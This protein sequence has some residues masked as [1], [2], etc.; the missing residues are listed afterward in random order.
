M[1]IGVLTHL[2]AENQWFSA[3]FLRSGVISS[4]SIL[5][6]FQHIGIA[7]LIMSLRS[8]KHFIPVAVFDEAVDFIDLVFIPVAIPP[9]RL[10]LIPG[11]MLFLRIDP[12][13]VFCLLN[14]VFVSW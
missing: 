8:F 9:E 12:G 11:V 3:L 2:C 7:A 1:I 4:I 14:Y 5:L 6:L 10:G 13:D